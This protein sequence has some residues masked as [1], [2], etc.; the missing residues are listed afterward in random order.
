MDR[1]ETIQSYLQS[2]LAEYLDLHRQMVSINSFTANAEGVNTLGDLTASVFSRFGF[3]SGRVAST[4]PLYGS[5]LFLNRRAQDRSN[6]AVALISHLDTVFPPGEE[7]A[8]DFYWRQE[9]DRIYGPGT[10]DIKGGTVMI[11][12]LLDV[13]SRFYPHLFDRVSWHVGLNATEEVLSE[14]FSRAC[15]VQFPPYTCACLVFEG[16]APSSDSFPLVTARKGRATFRVVAEGRSAHAGNY[17]H[18]GANAILQLAQTVQKVAELTDYRRQITFN[19]GTISGGV[20]VNRVPHYAEAEV[21]MRAFS[22]EVYDQG[23]ADMLALNG[24]SDVS[25]HNNGYHCKVNVEVVERTAP[26]P[27]NPKTQELY[28]IWERAGE[29]L[30]MRVAME[31]RGGLSD[32]NLL[33]NHY[34]TLDGL[35]PAGANAHCSERSIDGSK[36]QEYAK[37]SSFVPKAL[38][39]LAS[40]L[41]LLD[42]ARG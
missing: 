42:G 16:G 31:E 22:S 40:I 27:T 4:N 32:A 35:G 18:L 21:E 20:V 30:G 10:V 29:R 2:N 23:I 24:S 7:I 8:N 33:W 12:M 17:H 41:E 15:L 6:L 25:S 37:L 38:L 3:H 36:E 26:W 1:F 5:H 11:Y 28:R 13:V 34:P 39:N 14:E 19:V 9:G